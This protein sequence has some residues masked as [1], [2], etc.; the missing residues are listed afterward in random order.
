MIDELKKAMAVK[1]HLGMSDALGLGKL[2]WQ[3]VPFVTSPVGNARPPITI[4]WSINSVCNLHCK[5]CDV[6]QV[7]KDSNF[8]KNLC[9]TGKL[10]EVSLE[11]FKSVV[12]EVASFK[13]RMSITSTEPLMYKPLADAIAYS[14]NRGLEI[15]VT[16]NGYLLPKRAEEL[17]EA[18]LT[19]L[20]ISLDGAPDS[21]NDI[22]GRKD[23]FQKATEGIRLF[24]EACDR[25]GHN[26][27]IAINYTISNLNY[28]GL[29]AFYDSLTDLPVDKIT[30]GYMNYVT[31]SMAD[32][33]NALWGD[34]YA[35]TVNCLNED[36]QPDRV[37]VNALFEQ[38]QEVKR[39][40]KGRGKV[41]LVPDF[42]LNQLKRY[43]YEP[44]KFMGESR[45][46]VNW[47]IAEIIADGTVIPY[48]RCYHIPFGN[49][50]EKPF[51]EIWNGES[52]QSWR[53][54]LRKHQ[55]FPACTRCDQVY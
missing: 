2:A 10:A 11:R 34:K 50:N 28:Q 16:S 14:R 42:D 52:A 49:I 27:K 53:R 35:A 33:H 38:L 44:E 1:D 4:Y 6:G 36:T 37:D 51:M 30:F 48:T 40:D 46:M 22:R 20:N 41:A 45:C 24:K 3:A 26:A 21:H 8:Y 25:R 29:E 13:P 32:E 5:M 43:F 23:S 15:A 19:Q 12:D 55:R 9:I 31:Q 7:N 47:F 54:D 17:A 18:G 39:K